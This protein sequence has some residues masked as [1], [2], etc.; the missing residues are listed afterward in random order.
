MTDGRYSLDRVERDIKIL[1]AIFFI[2]V[3]I[4]AFGI[5]RFT[6]SAVT[7]PFTVSY[8]VLPPSGKSDEEILVLIR[9]N[10]PNDNEPLWAYVTWDHRT[11]VQRQGDVV[12]SKIH[13]NW[14]D[15]AFTP[16]QDL[17][18][19]GKHHIRIR[20]EDSDGN[21]VS[22]PV[23]EYTI[24]NTVPQVGWFDNLSEEAIAK[25]TG[26]PGGQGETGPQ[27]E[28]GETGPIGPQGEEGPPG[29]QGPIGGGEQ[30][31]VGSIGLP[32]GPG[33]RGETGPQG[34]TGKSENAIVL[35]TALILSI[36][37]MVTVLWGFYRERK[38]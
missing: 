21:I 17:C 5:G 14:W 11:I 3:V 12:F 30:G 16:P 22:W 10:H 7:H 25:I 32:G 37:S 35:Y 31:P 20:I 2:I 27:G 6:A 13:Q 29:A 34:E 18:A 36:A 8:Q 33:P 15:I 28:T 38:S 26:P 4:I 23:W 9:V 24:T 1:I 19:K